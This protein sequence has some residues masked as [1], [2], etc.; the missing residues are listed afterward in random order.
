MFQTLTCSVCILFLVHMFSGS[1]GVP[2]EKLSLIH[3]PALMDVVAND[4]NPITQDWSQ[5]SQKFSDILGYIGNG[6]PV[7]V[8][9]PNKEKQNFRGLHL[10]V[11]YF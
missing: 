3:C 8:S 6:R 10:R 5:E 11:Q 1:T 7:W 9:N 2:I 4:C